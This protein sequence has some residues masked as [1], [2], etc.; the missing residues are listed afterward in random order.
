MKVIS[1]SE[2]AAITGGASVGDAARTVCGVCSPDEPSDDKL[3]VIWNTASLAKI[4]AATPVLSIKGTI[5]GR[6]GIE[7]DSPRVALAELLSIFDRRVPP[8][9]GIHPSAVIGKGCVIG[10][11]ASIGP[12][13]V[14]AD[15][16][17]IGDRAVLQANVYVGAGA[18]IGADSRLE[19]G[20]V[21]HDFVE[22]GRR[23]TLHSG[24]V[25]GCDGFGHIKTPDGTWKK[26][27]QIGIVVIEDDVEIG[28]NSTIDRATFGTT[29]LRRGVRLGSLLHIAH[30]CD[31]GED[32][33][34]A[35]CSAVGGSVK[36]GRGALVAG[37]AGIAD[38]VT[39]GEGVTIAGRSGVT[40]N[41]KDGLTV[42]GFPA[43]D[44]AAENRFQ[45]SLRRVKDIPARLKRLE[46][47]LSCQCEDKGM[48]GDEL[49]PVRA[50][51]QPLQEQ[52]MDE[53]L[54]SQAGGGG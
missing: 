22:V 46:Q 32:S 24:V 54:T 15:G 34:I 44:H 30:N 39:V 26:I 1:L 50:A 37:M 13:C 21:I 12:C 19:A 14:I 35:G 28:A 17:R 41:V 42:S 7:H 47:L 18:I 9:S 5:D 51:V 2:A 16:A 31:I 3:C 33:L 45:A 52:P 36:I 20:A 23:V 48:K 6:D 53:D 43:Q 27:P 4:P 8:A 49:K 11:D 25:V 40:K 10:A 29:T 38:H